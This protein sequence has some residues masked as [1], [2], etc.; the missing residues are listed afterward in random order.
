MINIIFLKYPTN[1][2]Y[3][4]NNHKISLYTQNNILKSYTQIK[5][6]YETLKLIDHFPKYFIHDPIYTSEK[7]CSLVNN[8]ASI[9]LK[10][11]SEPGMDRSCNKTQ[12]AEPNIALISVMLLIGTFF[13]AHLLK[14]LRRSNFFGSYLRRTIRWLL[15]TTT[16]LIMILNFF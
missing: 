16:H 8:S 1:K 5:S 10:N 15:T 13:L 14:V 7:Y 3:T 9:C 11:M 12:G 6:R 2:F 4:Q